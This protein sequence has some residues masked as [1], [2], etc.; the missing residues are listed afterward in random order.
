M[1]FNMIYITHFKPHIRQSLGLFS[2]PAQYL[3]K[4]YHHNILLKKSKDN[5]KTASKFIY[6]FSFV[7]KI[8]CR[9]SNSNPRQFRCFFDHYHAI[10]YPQA[11]QMP[12]SKSVITG[13]TLCYTGKE[14]DMSMVMLWTFA[15]KVLKII[16]YLT[17]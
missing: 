10:S 2:G 1:N 17:T 15:G 6:S 7:F 8:S 5:L 13:D 11:G 12:L 4:I 9:N 16:C 3:Q 14:E